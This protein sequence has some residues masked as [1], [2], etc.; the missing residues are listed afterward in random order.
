MKRSI[1]KGLRDLVRLPWLM[2]QFW[3]ALGAWERRDWP[4]VILFIETPHA[5]CKKT[6]RVSELEPRPRRV[7]VEHL[8]R[9]QR[10]G[11]EVVADE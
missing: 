2:V 7:V 4:Q 3:R 11:V 8:D 6:P 9:I 1:W 10:I 5:I